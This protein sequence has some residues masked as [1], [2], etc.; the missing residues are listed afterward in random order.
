MRH[1]VAARLPRYR[2]A[3]NQLLAD[4]DPGGYMKVY[5]APDDEYDNH[6][7][8]VELTKASGLRA[9]DRGLGRR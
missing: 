3:M 4:V 7:R 6:Q 1:G 9:S 8:P 5:A 2:W